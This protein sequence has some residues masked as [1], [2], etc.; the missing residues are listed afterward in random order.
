M[1][2]T[3][4][5]KVLFHPAALLTIGDCLALVKA[6]GT[7]THAPP[8][9]AAAGLHARQGS[10]SAPADQPLAAAVAAAGG[11][12]A[13]AHAA[14]A[15]H[16]QRGPSAAHKAGAAG[17]AAG[18]AEVPPVEEQMGLTIPITQRVPQR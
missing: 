10:L 7:P 4:P 1:Q 8:H 18:N 9:G 6:L 14:G 5:L 15:P 11:G 13:P 17:I 12:A 16:H 3:E 2:S